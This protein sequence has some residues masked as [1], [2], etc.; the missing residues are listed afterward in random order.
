MKVSRKLATVINA[1]VGYGLNLSELTLIGHSLGSHLAGLTAK[2]L[3][4]TQKVGTI[5]GL[6]PASP[7]FSVSN[8]ENRL[9]KSDADYVLIIHTDIAMYGMIEPIGHGW[10]KKELIMI[11]FCIQ[12]V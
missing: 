4:F 2:K 8:I 11:E 7:G 10:Y 6:D 1:L 9:D 12:I 5:I 3:N